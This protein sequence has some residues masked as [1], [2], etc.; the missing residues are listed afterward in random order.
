MID[1][2]HTTKGVAHI[3][4]PLFLSNI[5]LQRIVANL[6]RILDV[7]R[8][9]A[10][11]TDKAFNVRC[12]LSA[13]HNPIQ[14]DSVTAI[15][16]PRLDDV[17]LHNVSLSSFCNNRTGAARHHCVSTGQDRQR[18]STLL[19]STSP[20]WSLRRCAL[21]GGAVRGR[22]NLRTPMP[23]KQRRQ[24]SPTSVKRYCCTSDLGSSGSD[25]SSLPP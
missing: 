14:V 15:L 9:D 7:V 5:V 3:V 10:E 16:F 4:H 2:H 6:F 19:R 8:C 24:P 25:A 12:T 18:D 13:W 1:K 21:Q 20:H 17:V 11:T 22:A 23:T